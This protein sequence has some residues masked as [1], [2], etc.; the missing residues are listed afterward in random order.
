MHQRA[1]QRAALLQDELARLQ[2]QVRDLQHRLFGPKTEAHHPPDAPPPTDNT[3]AGSDTTT[4]PTP[5][6]RRGQQPGHKGHG[7]RDYSHLPATTE[8][9]DL[10]P[11]Q[12]QCRRCGQPFAPFPGSEDSTLLEIEVKAHRRLIRRPRYR[13]TCT[14]GAHPGIVTAPPPP[15]LIP[16]SPFGISIWVSVLLDKYLSY[17]PTSRLLADLRSHGLDLSQ[18]AL[19]GG[20]RQLLPLF[21]PLYEALVQRS[22]HEDFWHA[23][24]TRWLVFATVEGKVGYRWYLWA[25]QS[26]QAVVFLLAAGRAH[27]VPE[28]HFG[29]VEGGI[30]VVDRYKAY[31]AIDKVKSGLIVLAFCSAH[32]RRDFLEMGRSWPREQAWAWGWV[33]R[34]G[35]LYHLNARRLELRE[36]SEGFAQRD[37]DLRV[38]V[39]GMAA[40]AEAELAA[41][42][43]HPARQ[44]VLE[45]LGNHWTGLTVFVEHPEVPMDNNAV[46]RTERGPVVGRKNYYGSGAVWSG[47]LAAM[48]FS[49]LATLRLWELN[50]R[51]WLTAYLTACAAA[52]GRAPADMSGYLPWNLSAEQRAAWAL[53]RQPAAGPGC[54]AGAQSDTS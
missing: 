1:T 37:Q 26:A 43:I 33:A 7:R 36:D 30:L 21:Q 5:Q 50:P 47:Q 53:P 54:G 9:L 8:V 52:G 24:E 42:D 32:Q 51:S 12:R 38:A 34:I 29:P 18:G 27:D 39:D 10:P 6:R 20:L 31:Q 49:L 13:P 14:C 28:E 40:Q 44:R 35:E 11:D 4:P 45:S 17:R 3:S 48:L 25:I 16:K 15:R 23:D 2:A 22:Q 46:E 41:P 19:T